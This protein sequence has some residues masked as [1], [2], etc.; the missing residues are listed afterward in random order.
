MTHSVRAFAPAPGSW[1]SIG[2]IYCYGVLTTASLSKVIPLLGDIGTHLGASPAQFALLISLMTI[3]PAALASVAGSIVD[4]MGAHRAL[5]IVAVIGVLVN[6]AYL[7]LDSL[8]TF[9]AVRVVEGLIAVGAYSAAPGLIMATA[10]DARRRRAMAVWSTYTAVGISL[11][12]ALSGSFAGTAHWRGGYVLHL[13]L[14]AVLLATSWM[15][16]VAPA[17]IGAARMQLKDLFSAWMQPG[18]LRLSLSFALL[19][20]VGFGMSTI[21]PEWYARQQL[22]EA[23]ALQAGEAVGR[24]SNILAV[25]NLVMIPGGFIAG[26]LLARGWRDVGLFTALIIATILCSLPLYMPGLADLPRQLTLVAWMLLQGAVIA[27]VTSALPRVVADPRQGA[28]AAGLLSQLAALVTFVTPLIWQPLLQKAVV[29]PAAWTG[30]IVV[31]AVAAAAS[32]VVFPRR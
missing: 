17:R 28:A 4:R 21:Y 27:V 14:F 6:A 9:M 11:G 10:S 5:Q 15:L 18:P 30:F 31:V 7:L 2:L 23:Y 1:V 25:A 20:V 32:W 24:A 3:L 29:E 16:P 12:L 13:A 19:I 8:G 22:A 26:A